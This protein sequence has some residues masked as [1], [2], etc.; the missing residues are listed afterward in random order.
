[1]EMHLTVF[2]KTHGAIAVFQIQNACTAKD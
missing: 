1:M 2:I